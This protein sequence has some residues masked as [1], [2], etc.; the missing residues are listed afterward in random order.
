M[1]QTQRD[2]NARRRP[3]GNA[4]NMLPVFVGLFVVVVAALGVAVMSQSAKDKAAGQGAPAVETG[5]AT[6]VFDDIDTSPEQFMRKGSGAKKTTTHDAP[7]GLAEA[8]VMVEARGLAQEGAALVSAALAAE[9]SGDQD[10]WRTNAASAREKYER[11]LE[12]TA[13]WHSDLIVKWGS[14]DAQLQK[15]EAEVG[16]W[17]KQLGRVRKAK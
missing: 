3:G 12:I 17:Q 10:A 8:A 5:G 1:A 9:K 7:P 2:P 15:I 14:S 11:A 16:V 4:P 13:D 6:N